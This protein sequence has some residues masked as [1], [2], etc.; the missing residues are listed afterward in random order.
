MGGGDGGDLGAGQSRWPLHLVMERP[1]A[2]SEA[3]AYWLRTAVGQGEF[4]NLP[5]DDVQALTRFGL[6]RV[7]RPGETL[8]SQGKWPVRVFL[9][10]TG[11]ADVVYATK[12]ERL[13]VEV[14]G[15]GST[16]GYLEMLLDITSPYEVVAR[17]EMD[18]LEF[19]RKLITTLIDVQPAI[20]FRWLRLIAHRLER[21]QRR[22][23]ELAGRSAHERLVHFLINE[24]DHRRTRYLALT[25]RDIA[26]SLGLSRQTVSRTLSRLEGEGLVRRGR[27][28][29]LLCDLMRLRDHAPR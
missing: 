29:L 2:G 23:V 26:N 24:S 6:Q 4:Q 21:S 25:Q 3:F 16:V 28:R 10:E 13:T 7:L 17:T 12:H 19:D 27:G 22:L 11:E 20:C 9:V 14:L 18:V 5:V 1:A 15:R 8:V